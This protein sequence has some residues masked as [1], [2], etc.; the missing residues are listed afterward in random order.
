MQATSILRQLSL[1]PNHSTLFRTYDAL[2]LLT[3][4]LIRYVPLSIEDFYFDASAVDCLF[5]TTFAS[6]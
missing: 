5:V 2:P 6:E 4:L 1:L 3:S